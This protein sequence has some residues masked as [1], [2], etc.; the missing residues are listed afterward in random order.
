[1]PARV[2]STMS[3]RAGFPVV[4]VRGGFSCFVSPGW[5]RLHQV[6]GGVGARWAVSHPFAA[7]VAA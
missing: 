4:G 7:A 6:L 2:W 5:G 1:M 3:G